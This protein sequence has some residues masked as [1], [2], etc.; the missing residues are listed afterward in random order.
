MAETEFKE[1]EMSKKAR[2]ILENLVDTGE[3]HADSVWGRE[4]KTLKYN[5]NLI[6]QFSNKKGLDI[7]KIYIETIRPYD[8]ENILLLKRCIEFNLSE[9]EVHEVIKERYR[10]SYNPKACKNQDFAREA[11]QKFYPELCKD[12]EIN[13]DKNFP[14]W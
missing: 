14:D 11:M 8:G 4:I 1:T 13:P 6:P 10:D 3:I 7:N 5:P 2:K 9:E 12:Y